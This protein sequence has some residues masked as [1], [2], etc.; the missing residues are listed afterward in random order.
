RACDRQKAEQ[1]LIE[2]EMRRRKSSNGR[3]DGDPGLICVSTQVVEAGVD[4]SAHRL[5]SEIAPWPS[6][7]QRLGRLN[8]DGRDNASKAYFWTE[9]KPDKRSRD[10][11]MWIGPY[12]EKDIKDANTLIEAAIRPSASRPFSEAVEIV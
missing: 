12:R 9:A 3:I 8:R 4:V 7:I 2:F 5:W 1:Q 6:V 10:G 11:E